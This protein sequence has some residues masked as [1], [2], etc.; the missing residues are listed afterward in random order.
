MQD[1]ILNYKKPIYFTKNIII[2]GW[3]TLRVFRDEQKAIVT[4]D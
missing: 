4:D 2:T 3:A 1:S